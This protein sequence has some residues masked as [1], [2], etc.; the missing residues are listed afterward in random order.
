MDEVTSKRKKHHPSHGHEEHLQNWFNHGSEH[1]HAEYD[2][3]GHHSWGAWG[4]WAPLGY[5]YG[6]DNDSDDASDSAPA[7][8]SGGDGGGSAT[9]RVMA[10]IRPDDEGARIAATR[11]FLSGLSLDALNRIVNNSAGDLDPVVFKRFRNNVLATYANFG[12]EFD[13]ESAVKSSKYRFVFY[14]GTLEVEPE[15]D[16]S[17]YR[18]MIENILRQNNKTMGDYDVEG[19]DVATGTIDKS[20][21]SLN[22]ELESLADDETQHQAIEAVQRW[23]D[24]LTTS[25][26]IQ[27]SQAGV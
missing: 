27:P 22:V 14:K 6:E 17:S 5:G 21:D 2:R 23:S 24:N 1:G 18:H 16:H 15:E 19:T 25:G 4:Y 13:R 10:G 9:S 11:A 20:D 26:P 3:R 8:D 7:A 12:W